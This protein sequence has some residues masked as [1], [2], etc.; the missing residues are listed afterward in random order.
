M[1]ITHWMG[2]R[3]CISRDQSGSCFL[4]ISSQLKCDTITKRS[5]R[6]VFSDVMSVHFIHVQN[7]SNLDIWFCVSFFN[8]WV[9]F[10][11]WIWVVKVSIMSVCMLFSGAANEPTIDP[12]GHKSLLNWNFCKLIAGTLDW[13]W[14]CIVGTPSDVWVVVFWRDSVMEMLFEQDNEEK[15][16]ATLVLDTLVKVT[17]VFIIEKYH[18][19]IW[20]FF[21]L[22]P[23]EMR[24][25]QNGYGI[26]VTLSVITGH[27]FV[28][29]D[30]SSDICVF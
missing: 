29:N 12:W 15:S 3:F 28:R 20:G 6:V 18:V 10:Y 24:C 5:K 23:Q 13:C 14:F 27:C 17:L 25:C 7:I 22:K 1:L 30:L 2:R 19:L 8:I 26:H 4:Y 21:L 11:Y 9:T 16:V